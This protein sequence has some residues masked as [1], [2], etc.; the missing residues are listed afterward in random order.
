MDYIILVKENKLNDI[1]QNLNIKWQS[2]KQKEFMHI[3]L[4]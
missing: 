3:N 2:Q 4:I 1:K